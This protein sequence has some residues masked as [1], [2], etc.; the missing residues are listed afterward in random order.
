MVKKA[1][2]LN[3]IS[4]LGRCSLT[5]DISVI[6][7][8]GIQACPLPTGV[9]TAQTGYSGYKCRELT[10]LIP[11]FR[12]MWKDAGFMP[13]GILTGFI[14]NDRQADEVIGVYNRFQGKWYNRKYR[15]IVDL[16]AELRKLF[17]KYGALCLT[18]KN[19]N[20]YLLGILKSLKQ[21]D[22]A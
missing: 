14:Q 17:K 8:M 11:A 16:N 15:C 12:T 1:A 20:E 5:A 19:T 21:M 10:D 6:T 9:Y 3:D 22:V 2:L 4:G 7:T 13:D 18:Q